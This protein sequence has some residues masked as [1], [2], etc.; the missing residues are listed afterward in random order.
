MG[1][2]PTHTHLGREPL[3]PTLT[4]GTRAVTKGSCSAE[5]CF[6]MWNRHFSRGWGEKQPGAETQGGSPGPCP[7]QLWFS[8]SWPGMPRS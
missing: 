1:H 7:Q 4:S 8:P 2:S 3:G 6:T 5:S